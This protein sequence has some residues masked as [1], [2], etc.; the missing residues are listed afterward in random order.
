MLSSL[1]DQANKKK[2]LIATLQCD[3]RLNG[4]IDIKI[5]SITKEH[6]DEQ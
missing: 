4:E 3:S 2:E 1:Q 5:R 6:A